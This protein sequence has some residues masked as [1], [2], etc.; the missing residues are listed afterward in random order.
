MSDAAGRIVLLNGTSS[1]GKTCLVDELLRAL[2]TPWFRMAVDDFNAMRSRGRTHSLS[3]QQLG[4][5]LRRTRAGFHRAVAGM[6]AGGNDVVV[7][8][9][10][11]ERWRLEDCLNVFRPFDVVFVAVRCE[12]RELERREQLRRDRPIGLATAQLEATHSHGHYDIEVD[13]TVQSAA[14]CAQQIA[15][16][17]ATSRRGRAFPALRS[18]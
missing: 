3:E 14:Q 5:V 18:P 9:V 16:W 6:A 10:L 7:D 13:T 12:T 8:Y 4:E 17:L 15:T 11:S 1:S 2:P